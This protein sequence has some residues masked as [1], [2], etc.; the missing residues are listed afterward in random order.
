MILRLTFI[1]HQELM[2][3]T[4]TRHHG[5]DRHLLVN[6][7]LQ[8]SGAFARALNQPPQTLLEVTNL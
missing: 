3:S 7:N 6:N 4:T 1:V 2:Q 5:Q 8:Q